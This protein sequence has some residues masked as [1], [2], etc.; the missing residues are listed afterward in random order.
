MARLLANLLTTR[1]SLRRAFPA[2]T[3]ATIERAIAASEAGHGAELRF[4]VET[5]LGPGA[6]LRG[7]TPRE[8][9]VEAFSNLHVW[10]T[11]ANNG[12]L[13]YLLLAERDIEIVADRGYNGKVSNAQWQAVCSAMEA[14]FRQGDYEQGAL[15]GIAAVG[16]L[17][18]EHFPPH[19]GDGNELPDKPAIL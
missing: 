2:R 13:I 10:D 4:A 18:R 7:I 16:T 8:R 1:W 14:A 3:L 17:L 6:V 9:A 15:A 12:V 5:A 11:T 19:A